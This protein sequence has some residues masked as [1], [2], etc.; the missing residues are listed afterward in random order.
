MIHLYGDLIIRYLSYQIIDL[1]CTP[2]TINTWKSI[3]MEIMCFMAMCF[4]LNIYKQHDFSRLVVELCLKLANRQV[5]R[6][7]S[8]DEMNRGIGTFDA[9][10]SQK[11]GAHFLEVSQSVVSRIPND[12]ICLAGSRRRSGTFNDSNPGPIYFPSGQAPTVLKRY[13]LSNDF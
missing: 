13:E 5:R 2:C 11:H 3:S 10:R 12:W 4:H 6:R 7:L 1:S 8:E 9:D